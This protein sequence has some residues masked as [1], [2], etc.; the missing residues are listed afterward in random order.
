M[1]ESSVN[2]KASRTIRRC[3]IIATLLIFGS[4]AGLL[5]GAAAVNRQSAAVFFAR[6]SSPKAL[7]LLGMFYLLYVPASLR[8]YYT[9]LLN[10]NGIFTAVERRNYQAGKQ[11]W[12]KYLA[13]SAVLAGILL[14]LMTIAG[15][16][17]S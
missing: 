13:G 2:L 16:V 4:L 7:L 6:F 17:N 11:K 10:A 15:N 12:E 9:L 8:I 3:R 1:N 5:G 14:I